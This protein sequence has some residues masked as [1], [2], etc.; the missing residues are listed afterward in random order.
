M[1]VQQLLFPAVVAAL[2]LRALYVGAEAFFT[3]RFTYRPGRNPRMVEVV[4]DAAQWSGIFVALVGVTLLALLLPR[5][6]LKPWLLGAL[7]FLD[8]VTFGIAVWVANA[9]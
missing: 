4:G 3:R 2:G 8:L 5:F 9:A 1:N 6:R 7:F